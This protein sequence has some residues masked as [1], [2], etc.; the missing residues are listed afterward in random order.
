MEKLTGK[1]SFCGDELHIERLRCKGC[2]IAV[3]GKSESAIGSFIGG[4]QGFHRVVCAIKRQLESHEQ[5]TGYL[6]S[7]YEKQVKPDY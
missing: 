4:R 1:C 2:N 7:H 6:I 5:T 3:E